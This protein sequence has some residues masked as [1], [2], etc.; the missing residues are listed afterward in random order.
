MKESN[1]KIKRKTIAE[2]RKLAVG[3]ILTGLGVAF[4]RR[5]NSNHYIPTF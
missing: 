5:Q 3:T 1:L 2:Q 4:I